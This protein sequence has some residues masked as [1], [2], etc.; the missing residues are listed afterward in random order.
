MGDADCYVEELF[1]TVGWQYPDVLA[2]VEITDITNPLDAPAH[3]TCRVT[4]VE[5]L[6]PSS[7]NVKRRWVGQQ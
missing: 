3:N 6:L 4:V 7:V 2:T 5:K 1:R